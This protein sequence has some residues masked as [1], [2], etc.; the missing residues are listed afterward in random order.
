MSKRIFASLRGT[1]TFIGA[2]L[3]NNEQTETPEVYDFWCAVWALGSIIGRKIYV[4]RPRAPVYL[5]WYVVLVADSG[6]TRKSTAVRTA[7]ELVRRFKPAFADMIEG[8]TTP[9]KLEAT[10]G[11]QSFSYQSAQAIISISELVTFMGRDRHSMAL[12]GLLT[13]LYDSPVQR[14]SPGSITGGSIAMRNVFVTLL[15]A[16][17]PTWLQTSINPDVIAGGFTSRCVFICSSDPKHRIAWPKQ[18]EGG[19]QDIDTQL[20]RLLERV[21]AYQTI[22][23]SDTALHDF[24]RWY[25]RRQLH[26]DAYRA[27]FESREDAHVLRLAACLCINDATFRVESHHIKTAMEVITNAKLSGYDIFSIHKQE[28]N[29]LEVGIEILRSALVSAGVDGIAGADLSVRMGRHLRGSEIRTTLRVMHELA[30]VQRFELRRDGAGR[31]K[32]IW[33]A[34]PALTAPD[35]LNVINE[36]IKDA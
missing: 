32:T 30:L 1:D 15:S 6:I 14:N 24:T 25:N 13:D 22:A 36:R 20:S 2:Y 26:D 19:Q 12:P 5:N 17:T 18:I 21:N 23:L 16:S 33:R 35:A 27:S 7:T 31:P 11:L 4:D 10:L 29:R 34:A 28:Q 9:E 3:R 8:K